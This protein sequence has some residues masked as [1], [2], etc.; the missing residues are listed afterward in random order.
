M[1]G[2]PRIWL[3]LTGIRTARAR[4]HITALPLDSFVNISMELARNNIDTS[5][6]IFP[7]PVDCSLQVCMY[8][9]KKCVADIPEGC[10]PLPC[11]TLK[12]SVVRYINQILTECSKEGG[13]CR[14][15]CA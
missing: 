2:Q 10:A 7:R 12:N 4:T 14:L 3:R 1:Q 6:M 13:R 11:R 15:L 8:S 5:G 9:Y